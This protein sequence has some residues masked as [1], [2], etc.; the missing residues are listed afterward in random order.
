MDREQQLVD[1]AF[2]LTLTMH[3]HPQTFAKMTPQ[4]VAE[5]TAKQL[6]N[7]GFDTTPVGASWGLLEQR[8]KRC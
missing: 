3:A 4:Q 7:C 8:T 5:W 6:R 2:D 1:I